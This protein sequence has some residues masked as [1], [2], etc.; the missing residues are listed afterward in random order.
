MI[1]ASRNNPLI[2]VLNISYDT[3]NLLHRW[4]GRIV[5][6]EVLAHAIAY[7]ASEVK[8]AGWKGLQEQITGG[9]LNTYGFIVSNIRQHYHPAPNSFLVGYSRD[10]C[11]RDPVKLGGT[12]RLL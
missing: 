1:L 5:A 7:G 2:N 4:F 11:N 8:T 10:R 3:F 12:A 6:L 9:G